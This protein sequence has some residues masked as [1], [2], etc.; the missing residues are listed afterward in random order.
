[1]PDRVG[2]K[3]YSRQK[4]LNETP[5]FKDL[6]R[7]AF[8]YFDL[9]RSARHHRPFN[10][11]ILS[12]KMSFMDDSRKSDQDRELRS[13]QP[14]A[15]YD[16]S[17]DPS[18]Y[19]EARNDQGGYDAAEH[20]SVPWSDLMMTMFVMFAVI[21]SAQLYE[22]EVV[23]AVQSEAKKIEVPPPQE[24]PIR[25]PSGEVILAPKIIYDMSHAVVDA[26]NLDNIDVVLEEDDRVR[27][28]VKGPLIFDLG[29]AELH[30]E[31]V[32]F[33]KKLSGLLR[34]INN[35][36]QVV[37]HTD[38]TPVRSKLFPT[39]WELSA[40][41]ASNVVKHL[42]QNGHLQPGRFSIVGRSMYRPQMPNITDKNRR[43]NRRVDIIITQKPYQGT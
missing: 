16:L 41:R 36:I 3:V 27:I 15:P 35:E 20:W 8:C 21:L 26:A 9:E 38:N 33:L 1:M 31:T 23:E 40:A 13:P 6:E 34:K 43:R 5:L 25:F 22:K 19:S 2:K 18:D 12:R 4:P 42:I 11:G 29:S 37:G 32:G 17:V 30:P 39:N 7:Y 10:P 28:S 14:W 24:S